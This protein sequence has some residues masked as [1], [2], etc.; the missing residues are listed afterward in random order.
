MLLL[1]LSHF[2]HVPLCAT[3]KTTAQQAR[4]SV[5]GILQA[6]VLEWVPLPSLLELLKEG[7][8]IYNYK[9]LKQVIHT[10]VSHRK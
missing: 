10:T 5:P 2:S 6:R 1:L 3:S 8:L 4:S 9:V 7:Y